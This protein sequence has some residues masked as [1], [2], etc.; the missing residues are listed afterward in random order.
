MFLNPLCKSDIAKDIPPIPAPIIP[1]LLYLLI[2][3]IIY[4]LK[5]LY[6]SVFKFNYDFSHAIIILYLILQSQL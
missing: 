5:L 6:L 2:C 1:I 4:A 3:F